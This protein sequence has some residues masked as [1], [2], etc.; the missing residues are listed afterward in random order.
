[1]PDPL[2]ERLHRYLDSGTDQSLDSLALLRP[3]Q[4]AALLDEDAML[5]LMLQMHRRGDEPVFLRRLVR[6][7]ERRRPGLHRRY[8][9]A[10]APLFSTLN[11]PQ[12]FPDHG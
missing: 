3:F 1:M 8:H 7:A 5:R 4:V 10:T 6:Y 2:H 11:H 9:S 12:T